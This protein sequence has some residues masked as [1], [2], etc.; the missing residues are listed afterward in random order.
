MCKQPYTALHSFYHQLCPDCAQVNWSKR[1]QL[2]DLS[3]RVALITGGRIKIGFATALK[4][5]RDGATVVATTRFPID[6][7][8]RYAAQPDF[9]DWQDRL[10]IVAVD[11]RNIP[12]VE[13]LAGQLNRELDSLDILIH[14]AAQT[15]KRPLAFYQHLLD[16][17]CDDQT[18]SLI[19]NDVAQS[20]L[21]ETGRGYGGQLMNV[22]QYFPEGSFDID[23]QQVDERGHHSWMMKL[24]EITTI[25]LLETYL[26]SAAAPFVL[27]RLL[28]PLM[29]RSPHPR[30][31][32]INVSAMEGQFERKNKTAFHPHTNMAKAAMNMMTR[33]SATDFANE[34]IFMNSVDTGW[35]TDEKPL[36]IAQRVQKEQAFYPPLDIV[37]G[38]ARIYDPIVRGCNESCEPLFG[39]FLKD[40]EPYAW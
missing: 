9:G 7:A 40:D 37:D 3:E 28:K 19:R 27:T 4:M 33:T 12:A 39:H 32:I 15:V 10:Q 18:M 2:A 23:G 20:V 21:L 29:I 26:V 24:D 31:F 25:E 6:A 1:E 14:N 22:N 35:I 38:A 13:S 11:L 30:R 34:G 36:P 16:A 17:R 8:K 5:L